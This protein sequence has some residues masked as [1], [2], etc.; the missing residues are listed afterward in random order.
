MGPYE[1]PSEHFSVLPSVLEWTA[2][3]YHGVWGERGEGWASPFA[4]GFLGGVLPSFAA[5][6][7][8]AQ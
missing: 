2:Y 7:L 8:Q 3:N 1:N 6:R 4:G 5:G